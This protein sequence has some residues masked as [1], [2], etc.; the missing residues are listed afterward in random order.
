MPENVRFH[1]RM[2]P[3]FFLSYK[4][5]LGII[6]T[7]GFILIFIWQRTAVDRLLAHRRLVHKHKTIPNLRGVVFNLSDFG[8]VGDGRT[9]NTMA[10]ERAIEEI[11]KRGGGQLNVLPGH[12]LTAPFN[13]TSHMTLFLAQNAVILG[14]DVCTPVVCFP[15]FLARLT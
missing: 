15:L 3:S 1:K 14:V 9:V 5:S 7:V 4:T 13:L 11:E 10:F 6:W 2:V 8:G 12:W